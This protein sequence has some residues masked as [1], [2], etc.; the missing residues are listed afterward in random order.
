[1]RVDGGHEQRFIAESRGVEPRRLDLTPMIGSLHDWQ[2][3]VNRDLLANDL[4]LEGIELGS[5]LA[6]QALEFQEAVRQCLLAWP[7]QWTQLVP[8][9]QLADAF[10]DKVLMLVFGKF[11][12]GKSSLCNFLAERFAARG[13]PVGYFRVEGGRIVDSD[14][15]FQEGVTETTANLQGVRLGNELILLDTPGLHSVTADNAELTRR[16]TD[17]A[18]GVLWLTSSSSPGQ[19]QELDELARELH[20]GKPLLPVI[21]RSDFYDE[22]EIDGEIVKRLCNKTPENRALQEADV[23]ARAQEKLRSMGVDVALLNA[24]VSVSVHV[25][26]H[27]GGS[28]AAMAAAGFEALYAALLAIA[29]PVLR[30]GQLKPAAVLLH[31]LDE[32]VAAD[33]REQLRPRLSVLQRAVEQAEQALPRR[34]DMF[35]ALVWRSVVPGLPALLERHAAARDVAAVRAG[36]AR[37][38]DEAL[39]RAGREAF[40]DFELVFPPSPPLQLEAG[41]GYH[42]LGDLVDDTGLH[43]ALQQAL[44]ER[45]DTLADGAQAHGRRALDR[46]SQEASR[47]DAILACHAQ[48]LCAL[49]SS[50]AHA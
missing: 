37:L 3:R 46:L 36:A 19:V 5:E 40:V 45:L 44:R 34:R 16:F 25:A 23:R 9:Q 15:P 21:T 6:Q 13:E 28:G 33:L 29:G 18:D 27:E 4:P 42:A 35:M 8:A 48:E 49:A 24:P 38:L 30:Y 12:A 26:R 31:H 39:A 2:A 11:N 7:R 47:L 43:A 50:L 22:D 10:D 17:S 32:H 20:R 1:M 41:V 14:Q